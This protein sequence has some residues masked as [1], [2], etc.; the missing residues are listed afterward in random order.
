MFDKSGNY[1]M[2]CMRAVLYVS[3]LKI[4]FSGLPDIRICLEK[5]MTDK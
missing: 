2:V 1:A 3:S 5:R 4:T